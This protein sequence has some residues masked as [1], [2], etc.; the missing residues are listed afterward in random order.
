MECSV[1]VQYLAC[2]ILTAGLL[3]VTIGVLVFKLIFYIIKKIKRGNNNGN[4][5]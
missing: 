5:N 1:F 4:R 3:V 2:I